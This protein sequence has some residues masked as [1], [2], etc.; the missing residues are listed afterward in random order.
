MYA[1]NPM[2]AS[3]NRKTAVIDPGVIQRH[4]G[5]RRFGA[6]KYVAANARSDPPSASSQ[7]VMLHAMA[8]KRLEICAAVIFSSKIKITR[9]ATSKRPM[10]H[11][12]PTEIA[13]CLVRERVSF[14]L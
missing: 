4:F 11:V 6:K 14:T 8:A 10:P 7:R 2:E 3:I 9:E 12:S 13:Y 1:F 5:L